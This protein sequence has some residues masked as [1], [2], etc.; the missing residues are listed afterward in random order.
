MRYW[1]FTEAALVK[2]A[3]TAYKYEIADKPLPFYR[4][5]VQDDNLQ[6]PNPVSHD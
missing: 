3:G 2:P 4:L 1:T 5:H 6:P